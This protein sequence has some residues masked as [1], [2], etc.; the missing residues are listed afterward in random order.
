[1]SQS[2]SRTEMP[3]P[4]PQ[5]EPDNETFWRAAGEG[6]FVIPRCVECAELIWIPRSF[7]PRC[8]GKTEWV[9]L[10]G[11]A[12]IYSYTEVHRGDGAYAATGP[13]VLAYVELAERGIRIMTNIVDSPAGELRIGQE[14]EAVFHPAGKETGV[15]RFRPVREEP[16]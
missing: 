16:R 14:V 8:M 11:R 3:T 6:R 7:C 13:F 9:E 12:T 5:T 15:P 4:E 10:S 1:M 2:M